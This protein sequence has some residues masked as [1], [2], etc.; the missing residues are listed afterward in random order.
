M[1]YEILSQINWNMVAAI[2]QLLGAIATFMAVWVSLYL[3]KNRVRPRLKVVVGERLT[4]GIPTVPENVLIIEVT[5]TGEMPAVVRS[6]GWS[7]GY[8]RRGPKCLTRRY[9]MQKPEALPV[10]CVPP[11]E[12]MPGRQNTTYFTLEFLLE[13]CRST[14]NPM[15][16]R[17]YPVFGRRGTRINAFV[18]LADGSLISVR[19]ERSL[20][21]KLIEAEQLAPR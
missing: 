12:L 6:F 18:N 8:F 1:R 9:A 4:F 11:Y 14:Q 20:R 10:G 2:G 3:A 13:Q 21:R 15:F 16:T 17:D 7:S 19:P 5:N